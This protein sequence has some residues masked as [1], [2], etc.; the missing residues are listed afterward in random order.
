MSIDRA[1]RLQ[2]AVTESVDILGKYISARVANG[3]AKKCA[4][5]AFVLRGILFE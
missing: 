2:S 4:V 5:R 3:I 1:A